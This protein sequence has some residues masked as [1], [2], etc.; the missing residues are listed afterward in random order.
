MTIVSP[1]TKRGKEIASKRKRVR[2]EILHD[3][4]ASDAAIAGLAACSPKLVASE[5]GEM[6]LEG[7][8]TDNKPRSPLEVE[9]FKRRD[10][11]EAVLEI[12]RRD[13]RIEELEAELARRS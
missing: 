12:H 11:D 6:K 2:L 8:L 10:F 1:R 4:F 9:M 3:E 13:D 7:L 5:R